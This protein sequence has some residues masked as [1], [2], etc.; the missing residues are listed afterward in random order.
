MFNA[1]AAAGGVRK[2]LD[3]YPD[4]P[5]EL[6]QEESS[7]G[8]AQLQSISELVEAKRLRRWPTRIG[9]HPIGGMVT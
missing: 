3:A 1:V 2:A 5:S 8:F 4:D 9:V 6:S 7:A